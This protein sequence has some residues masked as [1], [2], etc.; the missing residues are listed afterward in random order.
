MVAVTIGPGGSPGLERRGGYK[1]RKAVLLVAGL[2]LV[3]VVATAAD[4]PAGKETIKFEAKI[5]NVTFGHK[6]HVDYGA[7][8]EDCHHPVKDAEAKFLCSDC[9]DAKET[10]GNVLK[11]ADAVHKNCKGC[12]EKTVAA[13]KKA[14]SKDCKACHV[15]A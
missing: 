4:I 8:C 6:A 7:K 11:L 3:G 1:V 12:H 13:G 5:G 14:P 9:H 15:K 10:K 2:F